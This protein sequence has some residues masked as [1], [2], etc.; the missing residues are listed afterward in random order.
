MTVP[1]T[2]LTKAQLR[3]QSIVLG[4]DLAGRLVSVCNDFL[5]CNAIGVRWP[6][7]WKPCVFLFV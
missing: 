5:T 6:T 3:E 7:S 2:E 1:V 4:L